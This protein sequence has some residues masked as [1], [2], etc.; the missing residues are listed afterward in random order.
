MTRERLRIR[1]SRSGR[2]QRVLQIRGQGGDDRAR[3]DLRAT[4]RLLPAA[5]GNEEAHSALPPDE[6]HALIQPSVRIE[7]FSAA[8]DLSTGKAWG[9]SLLLEAKP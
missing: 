5:S 4:E 7:R 9:L 2:G 3:E 6:T 1:R 8:G